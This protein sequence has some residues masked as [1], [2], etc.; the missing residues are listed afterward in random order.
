MNNFIQVKFHTFDNHARLLDLFENKLG[1]DNAK[2]ALE[3]LEQQ[4]EP[5][6]LVSLNHFAEI[7]MVEKE[8]NV[9]LIS[10]YSDIIRIS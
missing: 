7:L 5:V 10:S 2:Q 9:I 4:N 8:E 6:A 1:I 3:A